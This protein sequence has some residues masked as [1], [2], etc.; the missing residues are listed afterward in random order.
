MINYISVN[1]KY[2]F[3]YYHT[4]HIDSAAEPKCKL[5]PNCSKPISTLPIGHKFLASNI[6]MHEQF[7]LKRQNKFVLQPRSTYNY[8]RRR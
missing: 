7:C 8:I 2:T 1:F 3:N 6:I 4:G 5:K